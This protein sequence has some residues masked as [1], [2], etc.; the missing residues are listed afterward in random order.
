MDTEK[1]ERKEIL[2]R[3]WETIDS[4][5][6][7]MIVLKISFT[8]S[9][10][11]KQHNLNWI[12]TSSSHSIK[13]SIQWL[14]WFSLESRTRFDQSS[15]THAKTFVRNPKLNRLKIVERLI[16]KKKILPLKNN[17]VPNTRE[18]IESSLIDE[19]IF[20]DIHVWSKILMNQS[21]VFEMIDFDRH[22]TWESR[23][24]NI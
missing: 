20:H 24:L 19:N 5:A 21:M 23:A 12:L 11:V 2:L 1:H 4:S 8:I 18:P 13:K 10:S 17:F 3:N 16:K 14:R 9:W 22:S 15:V 7:D 6:E